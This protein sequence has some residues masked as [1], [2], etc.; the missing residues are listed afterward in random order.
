MSHRSIEEYLTMLEKLLVIIGVHHKNN[1]QWLIIKLQYI[2]KIVRP[3]S[4]LI[5]VDVQNDFIS[6][7]LAIS[8][9]GGGNGAEVR[10]SQIRLWF[11]PLYNF[12]KIID[13]KN[14]QLI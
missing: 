5:V 3:I 9:F 13:I 10:C 4:A 14:G 1:S 11:W 8:D 12:I 7:S 6:G 2:L